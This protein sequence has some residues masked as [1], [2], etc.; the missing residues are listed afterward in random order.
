[1][2]GKLEGDMVRSRRV[3]CQG[4]QYRAA[5]LKTTIF[6]VVADYA[7]SARFVHSGIECELSA[8]IGRL[9][10]WHNAPP[11]DYF[12]GARDIVLRVA[13]SDSKCVQLENLA[14]EIFIESLV[15]TQT[16]E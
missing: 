6:V 4:K 11:G 1:M 2:G 15:A 12:G 7:V 8:A 13:R 5:L 14:R 10:W 9:A 16:S 3:L